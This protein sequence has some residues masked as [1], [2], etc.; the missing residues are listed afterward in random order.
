V[1]VGP[2]DRERRLAHLRGGS[3]AHLLA[4]PVSGIHAEESRQRVQVA[5]AVRVLEVAAVAADDD[6]HLVVVPH[7]GEVQPEVIEVGH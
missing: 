6:R 2:V 3:L 7:L 5:L 4:E 1:R